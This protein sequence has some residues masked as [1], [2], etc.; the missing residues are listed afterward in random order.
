MRKVNLP[1]ETMSRDDRARLFASLKPY[2]S[3]L[4]AVSGGADSVALLHLLCAWVAETD[5]AP[6]LEVATVDHGLRRDSADEARWVGALCAQLNV[7]HTTM[8]WEGL[9]PETGVQ[10]AART[11]RYHLLK[12]VCLQRK[13][14]QPTAIVTG[15]TQNDQAETVLMR[16]ARGSGV[17]GLG[18]MAPVRPLDQASGARIDLV[19]PLLGVSRHFLEQDLRLRDLRWC[20]DPSNQSTDYERVR[21]REALHHL[22]AL[23]VTVEAIAKS[24]GRAR[25]AAATL[26]AVADTVVTESVDVHAGVCASLPEDAFCSQPDE[27]QSRVLSRLITGF[28][29]SAAPPQLHKVERLAEAVCRDRKLAVTLGGTVVKKANGTIWVFREAGRSGLPEL[30]LHD[31]AKSVWDARFQVVWEPDRVCA[32]TAGHAVAVRALGPETV[33]QLRPSLSAA[34]EGLPFE[35]LQTVPGFWSGN[36]LIGVPTLK[37]QSDVCDGSHQPSVACGTPLVESG[38]GDCTGSCQAWFVGLS[39][40]QIGTRQ[41]SS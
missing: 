19:R 26:D 41:A 22:N 29:G 24:S 10:A 14:P 25:R 21:V 37:L 11:A 20:D 40:G 5:G 13:L 4:V 3:I 28:G 34:F 2:Q 16:L 30:S 15:H 8:P 27:I 9:K 7:P 33:S 6:V 23:G 36:R 39:S 17:D 31:H 18:G 32:G 35:A 38:H 1:G 12:Q